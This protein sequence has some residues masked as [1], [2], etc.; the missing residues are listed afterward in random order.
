MESKYKNRHFNG[1]FIEQ[2]NTDGFFNATMAG[3]FT[4]DDNS[5][6]RLLMPLMLN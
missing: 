1:Y 4:C 5:D 2:R 6:L 3:L